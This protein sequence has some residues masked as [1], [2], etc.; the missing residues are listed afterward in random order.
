MKRQVTPGKKK[1][2]EAASDSR[3]IIAAVACDQRQALKSLFG[4]VIGAEPENIPGERLV[5]FKEAVSRILTPHASAILLDPEYGLTAAR[6][7]AK[8]AGLLLAYEKTGYD[9]TTGG[10]LP[11][12]LEQWSV[13]R[14]A[15]AG[16]DCVKLLLYYSTTSAP[17]I[18]ER[19]HAFVER[20]GAECAAAD[21][22]SPNARI[23][24]G[25]LSRGCSKS[26]CAGEFGVCGRVSLL[27]REGFVPARGSY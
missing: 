2:L 25:T 24:P 7:R 4:K 13:Q 15:E 1:K 14:L 22:P 5:E 10:R 6:Q 20:V 18:N 9:A 3:G 16:A 17:D 11:R 12:L 23:F 27:R 19:K 21:V 8:S 26:R